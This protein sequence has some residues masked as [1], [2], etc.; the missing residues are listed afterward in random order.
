MVVE[1]DIIKKEIPC[2]EKINE[3]NYDNNILDLDDVY[4]FFSS[5]LNLGYKQ[6][7]KCY[8]VA[9]DIDDKILGYNMISS[10]T[11]NEC[12]CYNKN[13]LMFLLLIGACK[14]IMVH[15]HPN[16]Q[17]TPS[18]A[19]IA[20]ANYLKEIGEFF[21][22]E[23]VDSIIVTGKGWCGVLTNKGVDDYEIN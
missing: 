1:Y 10:G 4:M 8:I 19:D 22:I 13:A 20:T 3:F 23:F 16:Q 9:I 11:A 18:E 12:I 21:G 14:F 2:L 17:S 7:E 15:N 6:F 5:K